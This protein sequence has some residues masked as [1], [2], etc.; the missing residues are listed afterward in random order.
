M[1][2]RNVRSPFVF[3]TECD[4]SAVV[5]GLNAD[6]R[7]LTPEQKREI[8]SGKLLKASPS[9]SNKFFGVVRVPFHCPPTVLSLRASTKERVDHFGAAFPTG[10]HAVV[11]CCRRPRGIVSKRIC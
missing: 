2:G 3:D 8:L 6:R 7:H 10:G 5:R 4:P 9:P 1:I 11:R